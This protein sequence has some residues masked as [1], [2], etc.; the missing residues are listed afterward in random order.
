VENGKHWKFRRGKAAVLFLV[1]INKPHAIL[2]S[3]VK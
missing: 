3:D 2:L 1:Y